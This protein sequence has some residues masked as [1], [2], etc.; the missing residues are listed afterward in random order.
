KNARPRP[1]QGKHRARAKVLRQARAAHAGAGLGTATCGLEIKTGNI[2]PV[3]SFWIL[4]PQVCPAAR[5][6]QAK[7][8][9]RTEQA[10]GML[11]AIRVGKTTPG[12]SSSRGARSSETPNEKCRGSGEGTLSNFQNPKAP[13]RGVTSAPRASEIRL[14][15]AYTRLS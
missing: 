11:G 9:A 7:C 3:R 8:A 1:V 6:P 2:V 13:Y 14:H 4:Q 15:Y 10:A 5:A 12:R